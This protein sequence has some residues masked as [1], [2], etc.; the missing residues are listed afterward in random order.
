MCDAHL[1]IFDTMSLEEASKEY[2]KLSSLLLTEE[3][4]ARNLWSYGTTKWGPTFLLACGYP[5]SAANSLA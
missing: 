3:E 1:R 2:T 5:S 4:Y